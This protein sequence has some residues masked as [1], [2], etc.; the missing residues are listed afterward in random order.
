MGIER[1]KRLESKEINPLEMPVD[2]P[3]TFAFMNVGHVI[4]PSLESPTAQAVQKYYGL[5][6]YSLVT[7]SGIGI[8]I[9]NN[10]DTWFAEYQRKIRGYATKVINPN[11]LPPKYNHKGLYA[12]Q[13]TTQRC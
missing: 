9:S 3:N 10:V 7:R 2:Q 8:I 6:A 4:D 12:K 5:R 11:D 13:T 1:V